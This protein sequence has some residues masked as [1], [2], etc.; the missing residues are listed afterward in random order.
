MG[1]FTQA[2]GLLLCIGIAY[3]FMNG[4]CYSLFLLF[5]FLAPRG[6]ELE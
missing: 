6:S 5:D 2:V 3:I 1:Y 4:F